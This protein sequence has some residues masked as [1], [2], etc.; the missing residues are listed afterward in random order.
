MATSA[1][2]SMPQAAFSSS[3]LQDIMESD[4]QQLSTSRHRLH[5][6][7]SG[8]LPTTGGDGG[9]QVPSCSGLGAGGAYG[10]RLPHGR[11][12][13]RREREKR[14]QGGPKRGGAWR[15]RGMLAT[16][17]NLHSHPQLL[18]SSYAKASRSNTGPG[19]ATAESLNRSNSP[20]SDLLAT[21]PGGLQQGSRGGHPSYNAAASLASLLL[22]SQSG[23]NPKAETS[24]DPSR[25]KFDFGAL[26]RWVLCAR[27]CVCVC[28]RARVCVRAHG[29]RGSQ[30][31]L[32]I[33]DEREGGGL[34]CGGF[35]HALPLVHPHTFECRRFTPPHPHSHTA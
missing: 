13:G 7:K 14:S 18:A 24:R 27:N 17:P 5:K 15:A 6:S 29:G 19:A 4:G 20:A 25:S 32:Q 22:G 11:H 10:A 34:F 3:Q 23:S 1:S 30:R 28:A 31:G 9:C 21:K 2:I 16:D 12:E 26:L 35:V 8:G 33:Y